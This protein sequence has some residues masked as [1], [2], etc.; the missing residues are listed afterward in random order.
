MAFAATTFMILVVRMTMAFATAATP[1]VAMATTALVIVI[2][3]MVVSAATT[4]TGQQF[5]YLAGLQG[6]QGLGHGFSFGGKH[7]DALR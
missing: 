3:R 7:L 6:L 2:M 1:A 4:A 5:F